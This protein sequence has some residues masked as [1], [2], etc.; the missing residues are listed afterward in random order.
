M[1]SPLISLSPSLEEIRV[2]PFPIR[3]VRVQRRSLRDS[4]ER[5]LVNTSV[6]LGV[7]YLTPLRPG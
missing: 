6:Q 7:L 3:A 1:V 4:P 5:N 2:S